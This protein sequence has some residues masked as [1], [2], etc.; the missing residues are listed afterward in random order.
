MRA[1]LLSLDVAEAA[2]ATSSSAHFSTSPLKQRKDVPAYALYLLIAVA[3]ISSVISITL[4]VAWAVSLRH[5]PAGAITVIPSSSSS[6]G[7]AGPVT[8]VDAADNTTD[9]EPNVLVPNVPKYPPTTLMGQIKSHDLLH[10]LSGL[11]AVAMNYGS[12]NRAITGP[13]FNAS[14]DYLMANIQSKTNLVNIE[15]SYF[16]RAGSNTGVSNAFFSGSIMGKPLTPAVYPTDFRSYSN[17]GAV[18]NATAATL[19]F[20]DGGGCDAGNWT[21]A[22][23]D[24]PS[25]PFYVIVYRL[26]DCTDNNRIG[27]AS[28]FGATGIILASTA[29]SSGPAFGNAPLG[30]GIAVV[31][32]SNDYSVALINALETYGTSGVSVSV[33]LNVQYSRIVVSNVCGDTPAG[34]P[35]SVVLVGGHSDGV[36]RGPGTNDDGS[37][38]ISTLALAIAMTK[39]MSNASLNYQPV[40]MVKFCWFGAEEQGLLG[41]QEVVRVGLRRDN[42]P[43]AAVGTRARDWAIMIDLDMLGQ[44]PRHTRLIQPLQHTTLFIPPY[45]AL[46]DAIIAVAGSKNFQ[47]WVYDAN[48]FIP[49]GTPSRAFNGSIIMSDLFFEFFDANNLPRDSDLFDGRSDYGPFL[50]AGIPA[51]GVDAGADKTK[52]EANRQRYQRMTGWGGVANEENDQCYHQACDTIGNI[53]WGVYTN[54]TQSAAYVLEKLAFQSDLRQYLG[55][56]L[57]VASEP[58]EYGMLPF[59]YRFGPQ[60]REDDH[61]ERF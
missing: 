24:S 22:L 9:D 18:S 26:T 44:S 25:Q 10:M 60:V 28:M 6:T 13:G 11:Y 17:T 40:N 45:V 33:N 4:A 41:S 58:G 48:V 20:V 47:N 14:V 3:V 39:L 46:C 31:S 8:P 1:P 15:R 35:T 55:N 37:G 52:T 32:L 49:R 43:S 19:Y 51:G 2:T 56:P 36:A 54:M 38:S 61:L 21:D 5:S 12:G 59:E 29:P 23:G 42:D 57:G 7:V 27:F 30:T 50:A 34:D 16:L 53:H